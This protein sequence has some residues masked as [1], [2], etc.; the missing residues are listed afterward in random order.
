[1]N[2]LLI[3]IIFL[4]YCFVGM[5]CGLILYFN[6]DKPYINLWKNLIKKYKIIGCIIIFIIIHPAIL[7]TLICDIF[8]WIICK[9]SDLYILFFNKGDIIK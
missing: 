3:L 4:Y 7:V 5:F 2:E 1:M 8:W 6:Y 9:I